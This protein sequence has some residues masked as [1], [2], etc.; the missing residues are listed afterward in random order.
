MLFN[1]LEYLVF[2]PVVAIIYYILPGKARWVFLLAASLRFYMA[3]KPELVALMLFAV[4]ANYIC[5]LLMKG[6]GKRKRKALLIIAM[7]AN[8]SMLIW[9]KYLGFF[10]RSLEALAKA[11]GFGASFGDVSI[12]LPMGISFYTFQAAAYTIDVYRGSLE[13]ERNFFK[14]ALFISF[15]PQLVAGP[16]ERAKDLLGQL[17]ERKKPSMENISA[18]AKLLVIGFFKKA[19]VA[20]RLAPAVEWAYS[21]PARSEGLPALLATIFFAVQIYCDFSGYSD[22]AAGSARV[23]GIGLMQN[24]RQPYLSRSFKEFW[25]RWHISLSGWLRDYLYIPLGGSR[26]SKGRKW[27]N[28][29]VTFAASGLW[30]GAN[31]TYVAWGVLHGLFQVAEDM[32]SPLAKLFPKPVRA[33]LGMSATIA[34]TLFAWVFFR[35]KG[36]SEAWHII[37]HMADGFPKWG[38]RQGVF[39]VL[40][41][42]GGGLAA[43]LLALGLVIIAGLME[44]AGGNESLYLKAERWP[45]LAR[46]AAYGFL[47]ALILALGVYSNGGQFIYFQF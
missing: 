33:L 20:D 38:G 36:I 25:K 31:W 47:M 29:L 19:V 40:S 18:G 22:I 4:F 28:V 35:A 11:L 3:W 32:L 14:V 43:N 9:F 10:A 34:L 44:L 26:V 8:F 30:H 23:L 2:L 37:I 16:I 1:S 6:A 7:A 21:D 41:T 45:A 5:A 17:F 15:F 39:D 24:F 13:P 46:A 27:L 42:M 12:A